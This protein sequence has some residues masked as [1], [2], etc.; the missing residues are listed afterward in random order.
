MSD[1]SGS[2]R[3]I[4]D[5]PDAVAAGD[6]AVGGDTLSKL[7]TTVA[8]EATHAE[9]GLGGEHQDAV[10]PAG[11]TAPENGDAARELNRH[12]EGE[13]AALAE[14]RQTVGEWGQVLE[15]AMA[16][17]VGEAISGVREGLAKDSRELG[18]GRLEGIRVSC[19]PGATSL[20]GPVVEPQRADPV[21][22]VLDAR[23]AGIS[24]ASRQLGSER[25][26]DGEGGGGVS[27]REGLEALAGTGAATGEGSRGKAEGSRDFAAMDRPMPVPVKTPDHA[28]A[29]LQKLQGLSEAMG[30]HSAR[31]I[32]MFD[33]MIQSHRA[34]AR[35]QLAQH[36]E[37]NAIQAQ[38]RTLLAQAGNAQF[39]AQ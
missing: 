33:A 1:T 3:I 32:Q 2:K 26:D 29:E 11:R 8:S 25:I 5:G 23:A 24:S 16:G 12:G 13:R 36:L 22:Q 20:E 28:R 30:D 7:Q 38:L 14:V 35:I 27:G 15:S 31:V 39:N 21:A 37:I 19:Q 9:P 6:Q 17:P 4:E 18:E 10:K 34:A